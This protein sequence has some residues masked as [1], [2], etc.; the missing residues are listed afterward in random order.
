MAKRRAV[1]GGRPVVHGKVVHLPV[2]FR[3]VERPEPE[4]AEWAYFGLGILCSILAV[5]FFY[6]GLK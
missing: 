2:Q 4:K 1:S 5:Y 6:L 3:P